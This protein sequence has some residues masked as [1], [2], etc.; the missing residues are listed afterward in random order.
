MLFHSKARR[1]GGQTLRG[2]AALEDKVA[3]F[4]RDLERLG[5]DPESE[6]QEPSRRADR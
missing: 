2:L 6:G 5:T 4:R 1:I 3:A